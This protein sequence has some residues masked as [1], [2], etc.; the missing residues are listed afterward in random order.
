MRLF[1]VKENSIQ[2]GSIQFY[3]CKNI[4]NKKIE[5]N[6]IA[7]IEIENQ[8]HLFTIYLSYYKKMGK[9]IFQ[10]FW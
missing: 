3:F 10:I 4:C 2:G 7:T 5:D 9:I 6:V 8:I 1:N